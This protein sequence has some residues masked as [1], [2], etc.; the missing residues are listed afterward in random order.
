MLTAQERESGASVLIVA[1]MFM[2]L[3]GM[4]AVALDFGA[5]FNERRQNQTSADVGVI[6]GALDF[7]TPGMGE[8]GGPADGGCDEVLTYVRANL[9]NSYT[10]TE[11]ADIWR[12]CDDP[13]K[14]AGFGPIKVDTT[15]PLW[16]GFS[17]TRSDGTVFSD[18][19]DCI[20]RSSSEVR[21]RVPDQLLETSFGRVLDMDELATHAIAQARLLTG[22]GLG[23]VVPFGV[24]NG[25]NGYDCLLQPAAGISEEPCVGGTSGNYGAIFSQ[26]WGSEDTNTDCTVNQWG[27]EIRIGTAVGLDHFLEGVPDTSAFP[28]D[29]STFDTQVGQQNSYPAIDEATLLDRC[30]VD[31]NG[32]VIPWDQT[33]GSAMD[34][35][36]P[37][38]VEVDRGADAGDDTFKGLIIGTASDFPNATDPSSIKPRLVFDQGTCADSNT[39]V[40]PVGG[41]PA[42][43]LDL[44]G[45]G[46]YVVDDAPIWEWIL[47]GVDAEDYTDPDDLS[48]T[49]TGPINNPITM[50]CIL[51]SPDLMGPIFSDDIVK[52]RRFVWTPEFYYDEWGP[53]AHWQPIIGFKAAY[54][55][56]LWISTSGPGLRLYE[57]GTNPGQIDVTN[58][59]AMKALSSFIVPSVALPADVAN[60]CP[61][62]AGADVEPELSK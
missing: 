26:T 2:V 12:G 34:I 35:G 17:G 25:A 53:G 56:G 45:Y 27:P 52:S 36:V 57:P 60:G 5:G 13:N 61:T 46:T 41:V 6:A 14:P 11:W 8:C 54:L 55:H 51:R 21:V 23:A 7:F 10:D 16:T 31:A 47:F 39:A 9:S 44:G 38:T 33:V 28:P 24:L 43:C 49:C 42:R 22:G 48:S 4:A 3:L 18:T 20:S 32:D 50:D 62:C 40:S 58:P 30:E 59:N 1:S 29:V 37:N 19:V 15:D